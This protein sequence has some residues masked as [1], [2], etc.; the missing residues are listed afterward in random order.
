VKSSTN[1][2][3]FRKPEVFRYPEVFRNGE[4]FRYPEVFRNGEVFRSPE[5]FR[6]TT[7]KILSNST[8][9][10][11]TQHKINALTKKKY[12]LPYCQLNF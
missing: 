6:K 1:P 3:V 11:K 5:V 8:V 2:E 12:P 4:V 10:R 9:N 7:M